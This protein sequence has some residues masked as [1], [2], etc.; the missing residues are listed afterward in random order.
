M[1][2]KRLARDIYNLLDDIRKN[3]IK[4]IYIYFDENN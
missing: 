1:I 2:N 3:I 4:N